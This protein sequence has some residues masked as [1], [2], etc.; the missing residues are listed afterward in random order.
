MIRKILYLFIFIV[1]LVIISRQFIRL[2]FEPLSIYEAIPVTVPLFITLPDNAVS[3]LPDSLDPKLDSWIALFPGLQDDF[4]HLDTLVKRKEGFSSNIRKGALMIQKLEKDRWGMSVL[5]DMKNAR[6][7]LA[8]ILNQYATSEVI[9]TRFKG[10]NVYQIKPSDGSSFSVGR[11]RNLLILGRL[12]IAVEDVIRQLSEYRSG[13]DDKGDFKSLRQENKTS[14]LP[15]VFLQSGFFSDYFLNNMSS[16]AFE[17]LQAMENTFQWIRLD[18]EN[19]DDKLLL[20]GALLASEENNRVQAFARQEPQQPE[21]V[22]KLIPDD[23]ALFYYWG[24]SDFQAYYDAIN[25]PVID[26][27]ERFI[28]PWVGE[29]II[30]VVVDPA[31]NS[32]CLLIKPKDPVMAKQT[33]D[34]LLGEAGQLQAYVYNSFQVQQVLEEDLFGFLPF[35]PVTALRNPHIT[36]LNEYVLFAPSRSALEIWLDQYVVGGTLAV[37]PDF[38]HFRENQSDALHHLLYFNAKNWPRGRNKAT[39]EPFLN[40]YPYLGLSLRSKEGAFQ[41]SLTGTSTLKQDSTGNM[42]WRSNLSTEVIMPPQL[43]GLGERGRQVVVTQDA[44]YNFYVF[45]AGGNLLWQKKLDG[46]VQS[47]VWNFE[48][49]GDA[50]SQLLLNTKKNIYC[51]DEQG[52]S[53]PNFPIP[54]RSLASCGLT[55]ADFKQDNNP[56]FFIPCENGQ[57]YGFD[58]RGQPLA[59]WNPLFDVGQL[60]YP[61][62]YFQKGVNDYLVA[63]NDTAAIKVFA[64]NGE[65]QFELAD[66]SAVFNTPPSFELGTPSDRIVAVDQ[67]GIAHILNLQGEYFRLALRVGKNENVKFAF[68]DVLGDNRRDYIVMSGNDLAIYHYSEHGFV[69]ALE[70]QLQE[71]YS[72]LFVVPVMDQQKT[73]IGVFDQKSQKVNLLDAKGENWPGFPITSTLPIQV[74]DLFNDG[75][76]I[77]LGA[78]GST[79]F[80]MTL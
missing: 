60:S 42:L 2:P 58:K 40:E 6:H 51:L 48:Y 29:E 37:D 33:L 74:V 11:Y 55:L 30:Q 9:Q 54:L 4:V 34:R 35:G 80:G 50:H 79:I 76:P 5:M 14:K 41:L 24:F 10:Q 16:S 25:V 49:Y 38:L 44:F 77:V 13:L 31:S 67:T 43:I 73:L 70:K 75:R 12:P 45:E 27:F 69:R 20:N 15:A 39:L 66:S 3:I 8:F 1:V 68:A 18:L 64:K 7:A 71:S 23:I 61:I 57:V 53:L 22:F 21:K 62:M 63:L 52:R 46:P 47:S 56:A 26:R 78:N 72:Q 19:G 28:K 32:T 17:R 36:F 65:L 59:G